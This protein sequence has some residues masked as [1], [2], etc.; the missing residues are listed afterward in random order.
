MRFGDLKK[1]HRTLWQKATFSKYCQ[2][3]IQ[4]CLANIWL[5][6]LWNNLESIWKKNFQLGK[7]K[8]SQAV[9]GTS[10]IMDLYSIEFITTPPLTCELWHFSWK[11]KKMKIPKTFTEEFILEAGY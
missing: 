6:Q 10:L 4:A 8:T 2:L 3:A 11:S 5:F 7:I 9:N 1:F